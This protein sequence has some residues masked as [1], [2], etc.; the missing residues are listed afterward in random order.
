[1]TATS[2]SHHTPRASIKDP[3]RNRIRSKAEILNVIFPLLENEFVFPLEREFYQ[4]IVN[5]VQLN[6]T[7]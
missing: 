3:L 4:A 7:R 5:L 6:L 1:M 2:L